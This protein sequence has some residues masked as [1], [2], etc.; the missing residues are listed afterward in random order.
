MLPNNCEDSIRSDEVSSQL[1][2]SINDPVFGKHEANIFTQ[3][4][5]EG[6][7]SFGTVTQ[8]DSMVLVLAYRS[9]YGDTSFRQ[10]LNVYR[11][12][13]AI[14]ID[15]S[16]NT[17]QTF[18]YDAVPLGSLTYYPRP[19]SKIVVDSDT[20]APQIRI[21][22]SQAL[23][24]DIMH[25]NGS[26]ILST[27]S[28]WLNYFRGLFIKSDPISSGTGCISYFDF[29]H[30]SMVIYYHDSGNTIKNY[31]F[32]LAGA[33]VNSFQHNFM[34][35]DVEMQ[36]NDSTAIDSLNYLESM[37]GLKTK[38]Y[39]PFLKHFTDSGS[40]V[41]NKAELEIHVRGRALLRSEEHRLNSSHG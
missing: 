34:G 23:A 32:S 1:L 3:T 13:E 6:I 40:I 39:L 28:N 16:Y 4:V 24:N 15:S 14:H 26:S 30:S 31:S 38:I 11:L 21:R 17:N 19:F 22:L 35:T 20:V 25:L 2:G 36:L 33:R 29:F 7:P 27:G 18:A 10:S 41:I 12:S 8:A 5:L 9:Y 37:G